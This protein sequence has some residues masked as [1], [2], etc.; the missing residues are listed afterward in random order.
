MNTYQIT[1]TVTST[2]IVQG[3]TEADA[4]LLADSLSESDWAPYHFD[5]EV[6]FLDGPEELDEY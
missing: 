4:L 2:A 6:E 5:Q 1:R 3:Q